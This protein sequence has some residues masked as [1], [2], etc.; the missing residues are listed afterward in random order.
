MGVEVGIEGSTGAVEE[1]AGH[2]P[3]GRLERRLALTAPSNAGGLPLQVIGDLDH[4]AGVAPAHLV[5][6][7]GRPQE[8][9]DAHRLGGTKG[10][11]EAGHAAGAGR[12]PQSRP[13]S[14]IPTL[15][16]LPELPRTDGPRHPQSRGARP[17]QSPGLSPATPV[18]SARPGTR[19]S[20]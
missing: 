10:E 11:V 6:H 9:K 20:T 8:M 13:R 19:S 15:E 2:H 5:G 1:T 7:F 17:V 12:H 3:D 4:R 16:D 18:P 14:R